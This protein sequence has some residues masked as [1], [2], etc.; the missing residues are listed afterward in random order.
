MA[1]YEWDFAFVLNYRDV[2][3]EGF[4]GTLKIGF[5]SLALGIVIGL[6]L[7]VMR[8]SKHWFVKAP[9]IAVIEFFRATPVLVLLFWCYYALPIMVGVAFDAFTAVI[10]TLGIQTGAF[11]ARQ[12]QGGLVVA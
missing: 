1:A 11:M 8:L 7:A 3:F 6:V 9:A 12:Q 2:L 10:I 5:T 4:L